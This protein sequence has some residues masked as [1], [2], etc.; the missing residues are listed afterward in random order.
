MLIGETFSGKSSL[1]R[2][3]SEDVYT[4]RR[5]MAVEYFGRFV[6]TPG[7]FLENRRF[8]HALIT[9]AADCDTLFFVQDTTRN[10]CLFPPLFASMFNRKIIGIL[11]K[12]DK[13]KSNSTL[14]TRFLENAGVKEIIATSVIAGD[15][16]DRLQLLI[17]N[18]AVTSQQ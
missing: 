4:P 5:A 16:L 17:S 6:N 13:E 7:E 11:S 15:G 9:S 14:A 8:Y 1:I 10:S 2:A 12:I 3:L 18:T